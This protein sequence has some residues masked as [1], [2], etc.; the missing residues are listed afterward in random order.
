MTPKQQAIENWKAEWENST[1]GSEYC[2]FLEDRLWMATQWLS[3][4]DVATEYCAIIGKTLKDV[5]DEELH[6]EVGRISE[7]DMLD[8][9][10]RFSKE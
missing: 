6:N 10:S 2:E 7:Q 1:D 5:F 8:F 3:D 4:D 9:I